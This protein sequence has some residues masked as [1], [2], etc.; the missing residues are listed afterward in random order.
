MRILL[1][2]ASGTLGLS[3]L[4]Q[5][6]H[7]GHQ[8]RA[9]DLQTESTSRALMPFAGRAELRFGDLRNSS[10]VRAAVQNVEAILHLGAVTLPLS[11]LEP[12]HAEHVNVEGTRHLLAAAREL[13][14]PPHFVFTSSVAIY[15]PPEAHNDAQLT[16]DTPCKPNNAYGRHK[17]L[18]EADIRA[19]G[20]PFT[21]LRIGFS[22]PR[23]VPAG[24]ARFLP[25]LFAHALESRLEFI[26]P[27]DVATALA[28]VLEVP[29][30][31]GQTLLIG[32]GPHCQLSQRRLLQGLFETAGLGML[33]DQAFGTLPLFGGFLDTRESQALLAYQ[34]HSFEDYLAELRR[35]LGLKRWGVGLFSPFARRFLLNHSER[36]QR[37]LREKA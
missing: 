36:Y 9:F 22:L 1:T 20:L 34:K 7:R 17:L 25:Y 33:P 6:L 10:E 3:L 2:G 8:V 28:R 12:A 35:G 37:Y 23:K 13:P 32:G 19:S 27:E 29:A 16:V 15:G 21:L 24:D 5:L 18:C 14:A 26:H 11:E 31:R 4:P 30:A